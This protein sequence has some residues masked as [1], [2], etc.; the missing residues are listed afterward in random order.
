[1]VALPRIVTLNWSKRWKLIQTLMGIVPVL[2]KLPLGNQTFSGWFS[3]HR[4]RWR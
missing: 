3:A 2:R 1:M 4:A